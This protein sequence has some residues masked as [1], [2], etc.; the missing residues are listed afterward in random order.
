MKTQKPDLLDRSAL[1]HSAVDLLSRRDH[2]RQE[3]WRKLSPKASSADDLEFVLNDLTERNW[4]SDER[5]AAMYLRARGNRGVGPLRLK[6]ELRH[7][8]ISSELTSEI[9][10]VSDTDWTNNA[11]EV[12]RK[13]ANSI[14]FDHPQ[15][16][17]K[18]WRFLSYR[19]FSS[20]LIES[21]VSKIMTE[22][23]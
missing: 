3:L 2:S 6:Q 17:L 19:G 10:E 5:F 20:D 4:Q 21:V 16:K 11:M 13:K 22:S 14:G 23:T 15:L 12:G 8:G 1:M 7:K 9:M 18:L